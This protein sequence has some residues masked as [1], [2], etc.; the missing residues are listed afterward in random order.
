[1]PFHEEYSSEAH[2]YNED[3]VADVSDSENTKIFACE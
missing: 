1:M 2:K 3:E